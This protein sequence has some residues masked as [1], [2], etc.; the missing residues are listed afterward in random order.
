MVQL[1]VYV[2]ASPSLSNGV[3]N[4]I[5]LE[6]LQHLI[7]H[8]YSFLLLKTLLGHGVLVSVLPHLRG[9]TDTFW[10]R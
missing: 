2:R 10:S 5:M 7:A 9:T 8:L 3:D 6:M 1:Y 4:I